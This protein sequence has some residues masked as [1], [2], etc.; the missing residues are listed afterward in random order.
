MG[1]AS[2]AKRG[3]A[4]VPPRGERKNEELRKKGKEKDAQ[5]QG[6]ERRG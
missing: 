5:V 1:P 4:T 2:D 3:I 6:R